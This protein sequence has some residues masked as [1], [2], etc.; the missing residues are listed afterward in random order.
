[1]KKSSYILK[2]LFDIRPMTSTGNLHWE[3]ILKVKKH[4]NLRMAVEKPASKAA[5]TLPPSSSLLPD[6]RPA[7]EVFAPILT[8]YYQPK[9]TASFLSTD[10]L[11]LKKK[12]EN[13]LLELETILN[14]KHISPFYNVPIRQLKE[15]ST[16]MPRR[17]M[18]QMLPRVKKPSGQKLPITRF[19]IFLVG[20]LFFLASSAFLLF[21]GQ[22]ENSQKKQS[23]VVSSIM[24]AVEKEPEMSLARQGADIPEHMSAILDLFDI[25]RD[26]NIL[27]LFQNP[28]KIRATGGFINTYK[29]IAIDNGKIQKIF[30][31][32][33]FNLDGQLQA[34]IIP[35][36]PL[37]KNATAWSTHDSN[38]FFDFPSSAKKIAWF[39]KM[40]SGEKVDAV[41]VVNPAAVDNLIKVS[42]S[43]EQLFSDKENLLQIIKVL[44]KSAAEKD[45]IFY[46]VDS[47]A[48]ELVAA[49]GWDGQILESQDDYL[50]IVLSNIN[51]PLSDE[52][53]KGNIDLIS[54]IS[55]DGQIINTLTVEYPG[56]AGVDY[57]RIYAPLGAELIDASGYVIKNDKAPIDYQKAGFEDDKDVS[58]IESSL[59]IDQKTG[60]DI[61][62]E[63]GKTVFANW[64]AI[65]SKNIVKVVYKYKLPKKFN[66]DSNYQVVFQKQSGS[67][68]ELNW[69]IHFPDGRQI[70]SSN[71][72]LSIDKS[73][74]NLKSDFK[75]DKILNL[76]IN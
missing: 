4:L 15:K 64:V 57:L 45:M 43:F 33:I 44:E 10:N 37:Q 55:D 65:D 32:N 20:A 17:I 26:Q 54:E 70:I 62:K 63:S 47:K 35:P 67:Q 72:E 31:N 18:L 30:T 19:T 36:L 60:I 6:G 42:G 53:I 12:R 22:S 51:S 23:L 27:F 34:K 5:L 24:P 49:R 59:I 1:M 14:D 25:Y 68:M 41:V 74:A 3:K 61:Y 73:S 50:A 75:E 66:F 29:T 56:K 69:Q 38:W 28:L 2:Q 40:A 39:Y 76:N 46:F 58:Q 7:K 8:N 71:K 16:R 21:G 48:Q 11:S 52:V 9:L 13:I